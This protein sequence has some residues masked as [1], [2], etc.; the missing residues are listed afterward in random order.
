M[1]KPNFKKM[2]LISDEKF[3]A[4]MTNSS[5]VNSNTHSIHSQDN[6]VCKVTE[7]KPFNNHTFTKPDVKPVE[8]MVERD[9]DKS[10]K[11]ECN[12]RQ[13]YSN[14]E[15]A[16]EKW[17]PVN[18]VLNTPFRKILT[19][20]YQFRK[21]ERKQKVVSPK[22]KRETGS[23]VYEDEDR[24]ITNNNKKRKSIDIQITPQKSRSRTKKKTEPQ[25]LNLK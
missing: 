20:K 9:N 24:V 8:T 17:L 19:R 16:S 13:H 23:S 2:Y 15:K 7:T 25:W 6:T 22:R 10:G 5:Q 21:G 1:I 18:K 4:F 3:Q 14:N 11:C 12:I